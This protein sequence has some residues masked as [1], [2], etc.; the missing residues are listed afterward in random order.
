MTIG[1]KIK[2]RAHTFSTDLRHISVQHRKRFVFGVQIYVTRTHEINQNGSRNALVIEQA[3]YLKTR[4]TAKS[5]TVINRTEKTVYAIFRTL[6]GILCYPDALWTCLVVT[7]NLILYVLF[8]SHY[9]FNFSLNIL[10][11]NWYNFIDNTYEYLF[12]KSGCYW[13]L[14]RFILSI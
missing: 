10:F 14:T 3:P 13:E 8:H 2:S 6:Y 1:P 9:T 12:M 7:N 5:R 11:D 4:V